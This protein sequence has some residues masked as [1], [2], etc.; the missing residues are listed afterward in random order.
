MMFI[1]AETKQQH[2]KLMRDFAKFF[3][4]CF[5]ITKTTIQEKLVLGIWAQFLPQG[6]EFE[7]TNLPKFK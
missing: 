2:Q 4:I 1:Q 7:Q 6:K 5:A 3:N